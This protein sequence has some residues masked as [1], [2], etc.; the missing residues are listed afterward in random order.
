MKRIAVRKDLGAL[1]E[2][3]IRKWE[4]RTRSRI[5]QKKI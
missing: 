4:D 3:K 5:N 2:K 1:M